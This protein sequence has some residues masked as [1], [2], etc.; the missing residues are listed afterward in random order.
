MPFI[1]LTKGPIGVCSEV[2]GSLIHKRCL[3]SN[4]ELINLRL[5][6]RKSAKRWFHVRG[7][8]KSDGDVCIAR[9]FDNVSRWRGS[10]QL[11]K[12]L[13]GPAIL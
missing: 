8:G 5:K 7:D 12:L 11:V 1:E 10:I 13:F 4:I 9:Y 3:R 2:R 6:A